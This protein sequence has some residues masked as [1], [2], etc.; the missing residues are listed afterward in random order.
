MP[1]AAPQAD[2]DDEALQALFRRLPAPAAILDACV[3]FVSVNA[4]FSSEFE[5]RPE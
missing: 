2:A 4:A 5:Y 1:D 3:R